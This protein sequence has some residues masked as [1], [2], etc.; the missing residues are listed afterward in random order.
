MR[1]SRRSSFTVGIVGAVLKPLDVFVHVPGNGPSGYCGEASLVLLPRYVVPHTPF[2]IEAL[3][4]ADGY[5]N[6]IE[7][8]VSF[9]SC[10]FEEL[11]QRF[12]LWPLLALI[13][14][15][16]RAGMSAKPQPKHH[17]TK[18]DFASLAC[19]TSIRCLFNT[20]IALFTSF[21]RWRFSS[22]LSFLSVHYI[23]AMMF[24]CLAFVGFDTQLAVM[25]FFISGMS[26]DAAQIHLEIS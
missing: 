21:S 1:A 19:F 13:V 14:A 12:Y 10:G 2:W 8:C 5:S 4:C 3:G 26:F 24:L 15:V 7:E 23:S 18:W 25:R 9:D 16:D 22:S 6:A 11:G 20:L 17:C